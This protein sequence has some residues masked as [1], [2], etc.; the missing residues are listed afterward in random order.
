MFTVWGSKSDALGFNCQCKSFDFLVSR[1]Y[2][3]AFLRKD[4]PTGLEGMPIFGDL[5]CRDAPFLYNNTVI[6]TSAAVGT[7]YQDHQF[8]SRGH[9]VG[10]ITVADSE[11]GAKEIKYEITVRSNRRD[12]LDDVTFIHPLVN[13]DGSV[14]KSRFVIETSRRTGGNDK[15][16]MKYD[17]KLF[18]PSNLKTLHISPHTPGHVQFAPGTGLNLDSL[19]VTAHS[20]SKINMILPNRE[21]K[22][23]KLSLEIYRGWIVGEVPI[24]EETSIFTQQGDGIVNVQVYPSPSNSNEALLRTITGAGR[25]D[26]TYFATK[27][28]KRQIKSTHLSSTNGDLYLNYHEAKFTGK[29]QLESRTHTV[30]GA[31]SIRNT[32][33]DDLGWTHYVGNPESRDEIYINS[34]GWTGL[35]F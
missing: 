10:T 14:A 8:I 35:Y 7:V 6:T 13:D 15:L 31:T 32:N 11:P 30:T 17:V 5:G 28:P 16:C 18:I 19:H 22:A 27:G 26:F 21:L 9:G 2:L 33:V 3:Q 25:S 29:I 4:A 34:R 20:M 23:K 24:V 12:L 1:L